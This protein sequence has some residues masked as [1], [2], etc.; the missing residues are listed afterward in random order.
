MN[1]E[2]PMK[3]KDG[4]LQKIKRWLQG[5]FK[6]EIA[7]STKVKKMEKEDN[8]LLKK[9]SFRESL[10]VESKEA[11]LFLQ[12]QL[13]EKKIKISDLTENQKDELIEIY[14]F[15]IEELKKNIEQKNKLL[16]K[17]E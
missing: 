3:I 4:I 1:S 7:I 12:R 13:E 16:K 9:D 2:L 8:E 6:K 14:E 11:I 15:Q 10:A 17:Y 5:L